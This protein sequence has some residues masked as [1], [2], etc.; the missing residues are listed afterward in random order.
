VTMTIADGAPRREHGYMQAS[1]A[2]GLG[3]RPRL[4]VLGPRVVDVG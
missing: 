4:D 2:P 1:S 3:V